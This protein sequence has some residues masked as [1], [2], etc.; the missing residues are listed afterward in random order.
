MILGK[1][2][3][4]EIKF[5][6]IQKWKIEILHG[7]DKIWRIWTEYAAHRKRMSNKHMIN[8]HNQDELIKNTS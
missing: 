8:P 3:V 7:K 2:L 6:Q 5:P 4:W 1:Y